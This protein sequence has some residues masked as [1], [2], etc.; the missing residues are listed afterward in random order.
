MVVT[1]FTTTVVYV[2]LSVDVVV[3]TGFVVFVVEV[4]VEVVVVVK[5]LIWVDDVMYSTVVPVICLNVVVAPPATVVVEI[6]PQGRCAVT[7]TLSK[8]IVKAMNI[9]VVFFIIFSRVVLYCLTIK[10][11]II[12]ESKIYYLIT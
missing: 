8:R 6:N 3:T 4:V 12:I 10:L 5:D 7:E 2:I 9:L 1:S 11:T